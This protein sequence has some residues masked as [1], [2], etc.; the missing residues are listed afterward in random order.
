V[1]TIAPVLIII[2]LA[3]VIFLPKILMS[4]PV[5][6]VF[7]S[8]S[9]L[10]TLISTATP[11]PT[12][13]PTPVITPVPTKSASPKPT[14]PVISGPPGAGYSSVSVHTEKGDFSVRIL[15]IDL[16]SSRMVTDTTNDSDCANNCPVTNLA[17][18][19][20]KN[21]GY[22]GVNGTYLC[23][24][25]Y[26]ECSGKT[27]SFD[28]PVWNTRLGHWINGGN[29]G[30]NG[31]AIFYTD[32][33]G[34]HYNQNANGFSGGL[35][36]GVVNYPGLVDNGNVQI[37]DGQSG[38]SDKQRGVNSKTGI[39]LIDSK[40]VIVVIASSANMQQ[41]AYIFKALGAKSALN[42]DNGGSTALY[43]NGRYLAGPGRNIP[44]AI[45]F[46]R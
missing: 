23:P 16:N 40:H 14:I 3:G 46:A 37:D 11:A 2:I 27:N 15:S 5:P 1:K 29:L 25:T 33:S 20:A 35:T 42:L 21:G 8:P 4:T 41:F 44:N 7:L 26:S 34:A 18:F 19:V 10:P 36:A 31:R 30:W 22:A 39:G 6:T 28:F 38:L 9:P 32:G 45:I 12:S 17:D 24:D 13:S 43:Y